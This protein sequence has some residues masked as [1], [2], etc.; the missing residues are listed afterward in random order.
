[1]KDRLSKIIDY[2]KEQNLDGVLLTSM[3]NVFYVSGFTGDNV[4]L[5]ISADKQILITD[6]RYT[7]QAREQSPHF[8]VITAKGSLV[9]ELADFNLKNLGFEADSVTCAQLDS[10][11]NSIK[12]CSFKDCS[13]F[14]KEI[15]T[16]KTEEE[17]ALIRKAAQIADSA[18]KH[19]CT[20]AKVGMTENDIALE[21]EFFM[22][23][24]GAEG[25]SFPTIVA[26][27]D[28]GAM[29]HAEPGDRVIKDGD[30]VVMDFGCKYKGYCSDMTRT[31]FF[32]RAEEEQVKVYNAVLSAQK[33]ALAQ[34]KAGVCENIPDKA[35]R[36][37][38]EKEG[39]EK[40]FTHSLG[41]GVGVQ[42][43]ED[44]RMAPKCTG[45]L[46]ENMLVT[47]EPGV[48]IDGF[49]GVRIEDLVVVTPDGYE[50]LTHSEKDVIIL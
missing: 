44:P 11:K 10:F 24:N 4:V 15:R 19:I 6:S 18:F 45:V 38:L 28:H 7:L 41:H 31:V 25:V 30:C 8:Q 12:D 3:P 34:I 40:Y 1:M 21:L 22:R 16:V 47:V 42:I 32:G 2:T 13:G 5:F 27:G 23:K 33:A 20:I 46:K 35:A 14:L 9:G 17:I 43:H 26:A 49:V 37:A 50:N 48:Y 39:L 29:P 36:D